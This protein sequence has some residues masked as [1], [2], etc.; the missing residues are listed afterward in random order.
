[1]QTSDCDANASLSS[2]RSRSSTAIPARASALRVAGTG[3]MPMTAGSTPATAVETTRAMRPQAERAGAL[4]LDDEHRRRPVVDPGAVARRHRAAFARTPA[5][6]GPAPP[7]RC[8][9]G[10]ARRGRRRWAR[11]S[12][13][14]PRSGRSG[15]RTGRPRSRRPRVAGFASANASCRSRTDPPALGD[16]L[17]GLAHRVRVVQLGELRVDEPPAERRVVQLARAAVPG[18]SALAIT[19]GRPGHRFDAAADEHVAVADRDR[20]RRRVDRLEPAS[21]TGG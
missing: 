2:T 3:P 6:A 16:V 20:V 4:R 17:G 10:D 7:A 19:Y 13:A 21:R 12:A 14:G 18:R 5:G 1:M 8:R 15:R 11:P 9:R